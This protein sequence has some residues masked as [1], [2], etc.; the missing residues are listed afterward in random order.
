MN[1]KILIKGLLQLTGQGWRVFEITEEFLNGLPGRENDP[2]SEE[3]KEHFLSGF[4]IR[5]QEAA[6]QRSDGNPLSLNGGKQLRPLRIYR[7]EHKQKG[8]GI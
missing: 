6:M 4:R 3:L 1:D 2:P 5:I 7:Y 8:K